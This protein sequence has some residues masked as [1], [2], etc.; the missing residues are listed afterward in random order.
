MVVYW[1]S[2]QMETLF[3][4]T[5]GNVLGSLLNR[6]FGAGILRRRG[7]KWLG[8]TQQRWSQAEGWFQNMGSELVTG[9]GF[10]IGDPL[11]I[12]AGTL[13]ISRARFLILVTFGKVVRYWILVYAI[14]IGSTSQ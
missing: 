7:A 8:I 3:W 2:F 1:D 9:L 5:L 6:E 13:G 12:V 11:T 10:V 14:E 4:A